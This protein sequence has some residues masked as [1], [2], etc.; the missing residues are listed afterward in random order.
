MQWQ[1]TRKNRFFQRNLSIEVKKWNHGWLIPDY[2]S[3]KMHGARARE[4]A[5][6]S[7]CPHKSYVYTFSWNLTA[8]SSISNNANEN[9]ST[10]GRFW[11]EVGHFPSVYKWPAGG[12]RPPSRR[13]WHLFTYSNIVMT[14]TTSRFHRQIIG[15]WSLRSFNN[16]K[17]ILDWFNK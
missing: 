5:C 7:R 14:P 16:S 13:S 12:Q 3:W 11:Y 8:E 1:A 6:D 4:T 15:H 17:A 9:D 2:N 10:Y